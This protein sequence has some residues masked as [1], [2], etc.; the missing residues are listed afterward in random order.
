MTD[1]F[2]AISI[3]L[4]CASTPTFSLV[5]SPV[6]GSTI[7]EER[8]V[9]KRITSL[10]VGGMPTAAPYSLNASA[11]RIST[12]SRAS[13][14]PL[15]LSTGGRSTLISFSR[16]AGVP[17]V[18]AAYIGWKQ[19]AVSAPKAATTS[20]RTAI[21]ANDIHDP[22]GNHDHLADGFAAQRRFY[23]IKLQNGSLNL[24]ILRIPGHCDIAALLAV[25][26]HHQG[27]AVFNQQISFD[28]GP[29][30]LR[31]QPRLPQH[32][33]A[34][35]R[36]M[37]HHGREQLNKNDRGL[38]DGPRNVWSQ[39]RGGFFRARQRVG[40]RVGE[41]ADIGQADVEMQLF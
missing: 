36:Q 19:P 11:L 30:R 7:S 23:R 20:S 38:S 33:P 3:R 14:E 4:N 5:G 18:C 34:L 21:L 24:R 28:F 39:V 27:H 32:P 17:S 12:P 6:A 1:L 41:F 2:E 8:V 40:Q 9:V 10:W 26:L 31:N 15:G 29:I 22:L 25:D 35:L 13:R 16:S 37:R